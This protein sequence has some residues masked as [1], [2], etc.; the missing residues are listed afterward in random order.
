MEYIISFK[1]TNFAIKAEQCLLDRKLNVRVLPL[2][3]LIRAGCGICLRV[4]EDEI[5]LAMQSLE[6]EGIDEIAVYSRT[7]EN[8]K[9]TYS[10]LENINAIYAR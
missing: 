10:K 6:E 4:N 7:E 5:D 8:N 1:N 2:P 3:S 9:L